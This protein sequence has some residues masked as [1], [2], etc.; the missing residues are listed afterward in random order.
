MS[1]G[2]DAPETAVEFSPE[3]AAAHWVQEDPERKAGEL[4]GGL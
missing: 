1:E 2:W 3:K 4:R